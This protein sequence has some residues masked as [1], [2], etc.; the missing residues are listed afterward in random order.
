MNYKIIVE[1]VINKG[2]WV[3]ANSAEEA[4]DKVEQMYK[5]GEFVLDGDAMVSYKQMCVEL[6]EEE[7]TE[8]TT[9]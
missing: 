6:P 7:Q 9:F 2:V 1:E 4:M 3:E 8:W 5:S